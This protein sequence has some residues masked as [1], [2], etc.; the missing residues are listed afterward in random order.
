M[1]ETGFL[2]IQIIIRC[3]LSLATRD[4]SMSKPLDLFV[5]TGI[6]YLNMYMRITK[7]YCF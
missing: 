6:V 7:W 5:E 2:T 4:E 1:I 3:N